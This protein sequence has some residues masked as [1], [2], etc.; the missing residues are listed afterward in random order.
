[1]SPWKGGR[2]A[3]SL[4]LLGFL[5]LKPSIRGR[6]LLSI[7]DLLGRKVGVHRWGS[8][9][10]VCCNHSVPDTRRPS[11]VG[12]CVPAWVQGK[13]VLVVW[14]TWHATLHSGLRVQHGRLGASFHPEKL[15]ARGPLRRA[16]GACGGH[17]GRQDPAVHAVAGGERGAQRDHELGDAERAG[18]ARGLRRAG[19][20]P[21]SGRHLVW[22][23]QDGGCQVG[24]PSRGRVVGRASERAGGQASGRAGKRARASGERESEAK[25]AQGGQQSK[26]A[27]PQRPLLP[28][29][30]LPRML[31]PPR[32]ALRNRLA[33]A[34]NKARLACHSGLDPQANLRGLTAGFWNGERTAVTA[35]LRLRGPLAP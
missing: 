35:P 15:A 6:G 29:E 32:D 19:P 30:G 24:R 9:S 8:V 31:L 14:R 28:V 12:G 16:A 23:V 11:L 26:G 3:R 20:P 33:A 13:P 18:R 5:G 17:T 2:P 10:G 22:P 27:G 7:L 1:M 25:A 4:G 34:S 21:G